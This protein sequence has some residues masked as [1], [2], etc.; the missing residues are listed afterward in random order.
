MNIIMCD[1]IMNERG[2]E[3]KKMKGRERGRERQGGREGVDE[4]E[5]VR[6]EED[7]ERGYI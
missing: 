4:S 1:D 6:R 2:E 3:G 7:G 5:R